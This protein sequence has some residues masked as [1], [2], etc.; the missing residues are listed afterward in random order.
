MKKLEL[1]ELFNY[2]MDEKIIILEKL[3]REGEIRKKDVEEI[4]ERFHS[5]QI[6]SREEAEALAKEADQHLARMD[7]IQEKVRIMILEI[8]F[9]I[10][11]IY[12]AK[13]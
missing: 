13:D 7:E 6:K 9:D 2:E 11:A 10:R 12:E 3:S 8:M 4:H 5:G 1:I